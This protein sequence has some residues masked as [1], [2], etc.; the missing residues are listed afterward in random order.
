[1]SP[2]YPEAA[3]KPGGGC[4]PFL[5]AALLAA[6]VVA[7]AAAP[8]AVGVLFFTN[9]FLFANVVPRYPDIKADLE[10]SNSALGAASAKPSKLPESMIWRAARM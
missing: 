3:A 9:G 8:V 4:R 1:M 6:G 2:S 5:L 10:L 7:P